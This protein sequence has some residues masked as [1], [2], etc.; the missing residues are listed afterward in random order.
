MTTSAAIRRALVT[1]GGSG[2]GLASAKHLLD[3]GLTV[4]IAGRTLAKL[5]DAAAS[6]GSDAV[7]VVACDVADEE[8][9]AA[10]VAAAGEGTGTLDVAVLAAG[11][12]SME[13]IVSH[14][15][16]TW[17][18][19]LAT[20]LTGAF[21]TIKHAAGA[22]KRSGSGGAIC[23]ISSI[24][25]PLTHRYMAAYCVSKA[26]LDS[27]VRNA[28]DELGRHEIRVNS[29][30]PS[31]VPT[32]LAAAFASSPEIVADYIDNIP[33]E[34][35]GTVDDVAAVVAFLCDP[36]ARWVTGQ[37]IGVDGGNTLRRAPNLTQIASMLFPDTY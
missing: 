36:A 2:I 5:E 31:L 14:S 33:V 9:V 1:G 16:D 26:G 15:K 13:P 22:M 8:S 34:R 18:A 4:T 20:N 24:A 32:D 3:A 11:T 21:L 12:G 37:C 27:L 25:S 35:L 19:V 10:A 28:A 29:V 30:Q 7:R 6:L 17:D 23:A